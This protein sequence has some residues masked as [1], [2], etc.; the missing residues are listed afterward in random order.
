MPN[1]LGSSP[2]VGEVGILP[3]ERLKMA[4][5]PSLIAYYLKSGTSNTRLA[6]F[7]I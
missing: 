5:I 4:L 2:S 7:K 6:A 3:G 1:W